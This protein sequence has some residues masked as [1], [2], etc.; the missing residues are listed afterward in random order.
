MHK[1]EEEDF[2][3]AALEKHDKPLKGN[4]DLLS[5]TRYQI[6]KYQITRYQ[7]V[8]YHKVWWTSIQSFAR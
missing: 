5:I 1:L 8:R 7:I 2:R 3:N 6:I 4:N